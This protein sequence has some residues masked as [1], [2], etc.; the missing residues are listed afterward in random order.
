V[1]SPMPDN[2]SI[3]YCS[4][5]RRIGA[6][7]GSVRWP[8]FQMGLRIKAVHWPLKPREME[9]YHQPQPRGLAFRGPGIFKIQPCVQHMK[10]RGRRTTGVGFRQVQGKS[11]IVVAALQGGI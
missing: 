4:S 2:T 1:F 3:N 5:P 9:R 8:D 11:K 10:L 6:G 7:R